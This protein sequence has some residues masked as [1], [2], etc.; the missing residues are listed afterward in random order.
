MANKAQTTKLQYDEAVATVLLLNGVTLVAEW[1]STVH[2][3]PEVSTVLGLKTSLSTTS[4]STHI[5]AMIQRVSR[6]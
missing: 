4:L 6:L 3:Q 2:D 1:G 5:N